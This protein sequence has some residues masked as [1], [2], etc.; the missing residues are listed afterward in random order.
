MATATETPKTPFAVE[1]T[2]KQQQF[3][4]CV[5]AY[6]QVGFGGARGPGKSFALCQ[7]ALRQSIAYPGNIGVLVRKDLVD[8]N[9]TTKKIMTRFVLPAYLQQGLHVRWVGGNRPT[10]E[11]AIN[12]AVSEIQWRDTKDE[13]SLMSA[14]LG[15]IGIDEAIE[16]SE[17]FVNTVSAALGRCP[18]PGG[19]HA[20]AR[21]FWASNPGP[22]WCKRGF[23]VGHDLA[24]QTYRVID[25]NGCNTDLV[26]AFVPALPRDNPH[27]PPDF[28]A[29]L[30]AQYPAI[31]V[32][33]YLEGDWDAF[34]GQVFDEFDEAIHVVGRRDLAGTGWVHIL[35]HDWGFRNVAAALIVS[36]DFDGRFWVWREYRAAGRTPE[37][38][39][40]HLKRLCEGIQP[41][42]RLIDPAAVDQSDGVTIAEKYVS[43]GIPFI[44]WRKRKHGPEGSL[45]FVKNLLRDRRLVITEDCAGLIDEM[46]NARWQELSASQSE[47]RNEYERMVDKDD[48][49]I[50]CLLGVVEWHRLKPAAPTVVED[51]L[52]MMIMRQ[53]REAG[54]DKQIEREKILR[55]S[56]PFS[57]Q[58]ELRSG[59]LSKL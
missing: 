25:G 26:R 36:I 53:A 57:T 27:N 39:L 46:K 4:A 51:Q 3:H 42:M 18:L 21:L 5:A 20:P 12:G 1:P 11:I 59:L 17:A 50:D 48:H 30:R 16:V 14:N 33:R 19:G 31:W 40:P 55:R 54:S 13:A 9:D 45:L 8:L 38:H 7:E 52:A 41:A 49:S 24:K 34:E 58:R 15:W 22:G 44:G 37:E 35:A 56:E 28:E 10:L 29:K 23:P 32:R 43:L 47:R 2:A 6:D